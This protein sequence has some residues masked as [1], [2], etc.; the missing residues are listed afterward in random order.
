MKKHTSSKGFHSPEF[1]GTAVVGERGQVVIPKEVRD[2]LDLSAGS[3]LI[4]FRHDKGAIV[5]IPI[6]RMQDTLDHLKQQ[7]TIIQKAIRK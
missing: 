3:R 1:L 5:M 4:V 6:E 7:F 2:E